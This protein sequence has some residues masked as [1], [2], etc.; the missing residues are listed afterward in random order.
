MQPS[1]T[2]ESTQCYTS[3]SPPAHRPVFHKR[4]ITPIHHFDQRVFKSQ[5]RIDQ[6]EILKALFEI[7]AMLEREKKKGSMAFKLKPKRPKVTRKDAIN[8][9]RR[10]IRQVILNQTYTNVAQ[11]ARYTRSDRE[12]VKRVM[13]DLQ[14]QGEVAHLEY[15]NVKS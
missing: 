1:L 6:D 13:S 15:N 12:T 3:R 10:L 7:Q 2:K 9:K 5:D 14:T 11:I 8:R 4:P